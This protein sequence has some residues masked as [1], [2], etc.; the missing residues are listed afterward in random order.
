MPLI[1]LFFIAVVCG[2]VGL[3]LGG[4]VAS[5]C[6]SWYHITSR[7]G[8]SGYFVIT[9]ALLS[10]VIA[11][12]LG[13]LMAHFLGANPTRGLLK[14]L[15]GS[16]GTIALM[17]GIICI[18]CRLLAPPADKNIAESTPVI[19][20][21]E[22]NPPTSPP[23]PSANDPLAEWLNRID[24]PSVAQAA[25]QHIP[26]RP[27][28]NQELRDLALS[29]SPQNAAAALSYIGNKSNPTPLWIPVAQEAAHDLAD[30]MRQFN[31]TPEEADPGFSGAAD[32]S[33]R[34]N[35]WIS[36]ALSLRQY[37]GAD[38]TPELRILLDLSRVRSESSVM[39]SDICRVASFYLHAWA[40]VPPLPTDPKPN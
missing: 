32:L 16:V 23:I 12:V 40:G 34:F 5:A 17:A 9:I 39:R 6:V 25:S 21:V 14:S 11:F 2:L 28:L 1:S 26:F 3:L 35:A 30:R 7:D 15:G 18:F 4:L 31:S 24:E 8:A 36:A 19:D 20:S 27:N 13:G 29:D 10:G 22:N 37:A 38:L 33:V